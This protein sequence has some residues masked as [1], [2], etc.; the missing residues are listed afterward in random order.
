[1]SEIIEE[2][3]KDLIPVYRYEIEHGNEVLRIDKPAGS[4]CPYAVIFRERLKIRG[5]SQEQDLPDSVNS[6]K[7]TDPHYPREFGYVSEISRHA[8]AG[9]L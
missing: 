6:W 7:C 5:T 4:K 2:L 1:M 9:P 3:S 8:I